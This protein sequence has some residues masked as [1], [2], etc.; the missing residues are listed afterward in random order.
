MK[1]LSLI[2]IVSSLTVLICLI[3]AALLFYSIQPSALII[4]AFIIGIITGALILALIL[5]LKN[6]IKNKK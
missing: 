6:N 3:L 4:L 2:V 1:N 5:S